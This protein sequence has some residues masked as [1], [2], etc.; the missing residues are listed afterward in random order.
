LGGR[1]GVNDKGI[2]SQKWIVVGLKTVYPL[3]NTTCK[4]IPLNNERIQY[5]QY[6]KI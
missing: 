3:Q 6:M 1:C 5:A 4:R 2:N